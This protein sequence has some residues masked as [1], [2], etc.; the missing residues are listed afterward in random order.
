MKTTL[1][2]SLTAA[3][4]LASVPASA[5]SLAADDYTIG[6]DKAAG[7]YTAGALKTQPG[8]VTPGFVDGGYASGTGTSQ[9][10]ATENGLPSFSAWA[11]ARATGSA[12]TPK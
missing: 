10:S 12:S 4:A 7:E 11:R 3:A 1:A 5:V 2:L 6:P 9:F 8:L